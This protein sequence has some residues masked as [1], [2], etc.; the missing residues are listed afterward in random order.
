MPEL[1]IVALAKA[2]AWL[3]TIPE[4]ER[5][6]WLSGSNAATTRPQPAPMS[7]QEQQ[8]TIEAAVKVATGSQSGAN[9]PAGEVPVAAIKEPKSQRSHQTTQVPT[10]ERLKIVEMLHMIGAEPTTDDLEFYRKSL[11]IDTREHNWI[12]CQ[13]TRAWKRG[14]DGEKTKHK[15]QNV[16]RR[17]ANSWLRSEIGQKKSP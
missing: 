4:E 13:L 9:P 2:F 12:V 1:N 3:V 6:L 14:M 5:L 10:M 11:P 8:S 17:T 16:G 7:A 15:K